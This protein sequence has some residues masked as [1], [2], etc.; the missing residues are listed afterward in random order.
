MRL[1][2]NFFAQPTLRLA[3]QLLGKQL[4]H[5]QNGLQISGLIVEVEAYLWRNDQACHAARGMT[6]KNRT[7]F[8]EPGMLYVYCI[9]ASWCMNVVS[10]RAGRGAAVLIRAVQPTSG[11]DAM[12]HNRGVESETEWT[13]G[14]GK[15][16][17]AFGIHRPHDGSDLV[18]H[19]NLWIE[20]CKGV[21][22]FRIRRSPRIGIRLGTEFLYRYF[23]DSNR[24][25]SGR[26]RDHS[27]SRNTELQCLAPSDPLRAIEP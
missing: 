27:A 22:P 26:A 21:T 16:C 24:F 10:E 19:P 12:R 17:Q 13:N 7:M 8:A 1:D 11:H 3:P 18:E 6:P 9:H 14:P 5:R 20:G 23:V 4:V 15:L 2:R 25:V